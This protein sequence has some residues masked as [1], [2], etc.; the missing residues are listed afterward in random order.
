MDFCFI[1]VYLPNIVS[2][3]ESF[4][5]ISPFL[6]TKRK[7]ILGGDFNFIENSVLDKTGGNSSLGCFWCKEMDIFKKGF[8]LIDMFRNKFPY[9]LGLIII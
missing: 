5:N 2:Q 9:I 1:N 4:L 6:V 8:D 7:V 3:R